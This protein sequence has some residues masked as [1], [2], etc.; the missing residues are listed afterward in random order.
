M[1]AYR[2]PAYRERG[3]DPAGGLRGD[4]Q[5]GQDPSAYGI[6]DRPECFVHDLYVTDWLRVFK[7][8]SQLDALHDIQ[9]MATPTLAC[10]SVA[11]CHSA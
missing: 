11:R 5:G 8:A 2:R 6:G 4:A 1:A 3:G 7:T 10:A 9:S